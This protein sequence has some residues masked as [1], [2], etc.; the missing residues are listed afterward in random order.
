M[1]TAQRGDL[2]SARRRRRARQSLHLRAGSAARAHAHADHVGVPARRGHHLSSR[3]RLAALSSGCRRSLAV[4]G[5]RVRLPGVPL[6]ARLDHRVPLLP[7]IGVVGVPGDS[8]RDAGHAAAHARGGRRGSSTVR[9]RLHAADPPLCRQP[10]RV[11]AHRE[12]HVDEGLRLHVHR[13]SPCD[14][15]DRHVSLA[16]VRKVLPHL[17]A[18]GATGRR[19]LQGRRAHPGTSPL[20]SLRPRV[21]LAHARRGSDRGRAAA[22][23]HVRDPGERGRATTN[24]SAR[25]AGGRR[26]S[27]RRGC[28]GRAAAAGSPLPDGRPLPMPVHA[29]QGLGQGPLGVEDADNFHP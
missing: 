6:S 19:V 16:A 2:G 17:S 21:Q 8:G 12:L 10:D 26:W 13:D 14:H 25:P 3:L 18:A 28:C 4:R 20:P 29:N 27:W 1:A 22:R 11:D 23:V 9:G 7:R 15:G 5:G 24:G